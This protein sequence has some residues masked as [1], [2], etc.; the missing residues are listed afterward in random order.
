VYGY[1]PNKKKYVG[2]WI[3][4]QSTSIQFQEG[5]LSAD[6]NTM[7]MTGEMKNPMGPG[8]VTI[9]MVDRFADENTRVFAMKIPMPGGGGGDI[10]LMTITYK[11]RK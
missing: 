11:R 9:K 3:D 5:E 7:I 1:D 2:V 10:D 4:T 6:G 8:M